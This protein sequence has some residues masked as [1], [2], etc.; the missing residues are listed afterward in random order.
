MPNEMMKYVD[1]SVNK[2][3]QQFRTWRSCKENEKTCRYKEIQY[4]WVYFGEKI[5][6]KP[7]PMN[8][9]RWTNPQYLDYLVFERTLVGYFGYQPFIVNFEIPKLT[10]MQEFNGE[11]SEPPKVNIEEA[12]KLIP[13]GWH[14]T[15]SYDDSFGI[16]PETLTTPCLLCL[17]GHE[18]GTQWIEISGGKQEVL[19]K[20]SKVSER[21]YCLGT[22]NPN[23]VE[24]LG[25]EIDMDAL[26]TKI[27]VGWYLTSIHGT[28]FGLKPTSRDVE[29]LLCKRVHEHENQWI[30][31]CG[32]KQSIFFKC[33]RADEEGS[34]RSKYLGELK[35]DAIVTEED[36]LRSIEYKNNKPQ[37]ETNEYYCE[38]YARPLNPIIGIILLLCSFMGTGKTTEFNNYI[39]RNN[40]KRVAVLSSRILYTESITS[41][42]NQ[43]QTEENKYYMLPFI[44]KKFQTY[45]E[46]NETGKRKDYRDCDRLVIQMES[47]HNLVNVAPFDVLILDEIES[48]LYQFGSGT[49]SQQILCCQVFEK[50][51]RETPIIIGGDA[52]LSEKSRKTLEKINPNVRIIRNDYKPVRRTANLYDTYEGLFYRA[53][54]SLGMGKKI[55]FVCASRRKA[56][57][58]ASGCEERGIVYKVYVGRSNNVDQER[59]ELRNVNKSWSGEVRCVI[60]NSRITVGVNYNKED[61]FDQLFVYGSSHSC[62]VR[63][64]FQGTLRVRH[65]KENVMYV[66]IYQKAT[67]GR[68]PLKEV[69]V[70]KYIEDMVIPKEELLKN[71]EPSKLTIV[72]E[73]PEN[74]LIKY[75]NRNPNS[76]HNGS[77]VL[78]NTLVQTITNLNS[79]RNAIINKMQTEGIVVTKMVG[80]R[81]IIDEDKVN[82]YIAK[83][84]IN[85]KRESGV[86]R[87]NKKVREYIAKSVWNYAPEWTK[88]CLIYNIME[89][90]ISKV[91]YRSEFEKYLVRCNYKVNEITP[92]KEGYDEG[93]SVR[94]EELKYSEISEIDK[95]TAKEIKWKLKA[96]LGNAMDYKMID[97]YEYDKMVKDDLPRERREALFNK[98]FANDRYNKYHFK[99]RYDERYETPESIA[100][101]V[102][103]HKY[104]ESASVR[105]N[106]LALIKTLNLAFGLQNSA[107]GFNV[108]EQQ[109]NVV[110]P[111]LYPYIPEMQKLFNAKSTDKNPTANLIKHLDKVYK[112][113]SGT[114][115][116]RT[117][118]RKQFNGIRQMQYTISK[119]HDQSVEE[120]VKPKLPKDQLKQVVNNQI[121][122]EM[123][124]IDLPTMLNISEQKSIELTQPQ[125][126]NR[127]Y[128]SIRSEILNWLVNYGIVKKNIN[129][130]ELVNAIRGL[131]YVNAF[132]LYK[133]PLR[134][135]KKYLSPYGISDNEKFTSI[136]SIY[137]QSIDLR[138]IEQLMNTGTVIRMT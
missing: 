33:R 25:S 91:C 71:E 138:Q 75:Q 121:T 103:S 115:I 9:E 90:N 6:W 44:G 38:K 15:K 34:K 100:R 102:V 37:I 106:K 35:P 66:N 89:G 93:G 17:S 94:V 27:P 18:T 132:K 131:G 50:L 81:L 11:G 61:E 72:E 95:S 28:S 59:E 42:Y 117:S 58:F 96:G 127:Q 125:V 62:C 45:L 14:I 5:S 114:G 108:P 20:C 124:T 70:R 126:E 97:K 84:V 69:D 40:P 7:R 134:E 113:W 60:Y 12:K 92:K 79:D 73:V 46:V 123:I 99:N 49:M 110:E 137:D 21:S 63:D 101:K 64:T 13:V 122:H 107:Q 1:M 3:N 82:E 36:R 55:V 30:T 112:D 16:E 136:S 119:E 51:I 48:L 65:I 74:L 23:Y 133:I 88:I 129:G 4:E 86:T 130:T 104:I 10:Y 109:F 120:S 53:Y 80:N 83:N 26:K 78:E 105:G 8:D 32:A 31:V 47:L 77:S 19:F 56:L 118:E 67:N 29:C 98:F 22:L 52:F 41:E 85:S 57:E 2:R 116:V 128:C 54:Q 24:M 76:S 68:L 43:S 111:S 135:V 87:Q 39:R